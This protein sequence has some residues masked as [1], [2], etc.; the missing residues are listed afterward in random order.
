G[1][2]GFILRN[3]SSFSPE[4]CTFIIAN[5]T[6]RSFEV[7]VPVVSRSNTTSGFF[8]FNFKISAFVV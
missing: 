2:V 7:L 5:S 4:G 6:I 8:K 1:T 3:F